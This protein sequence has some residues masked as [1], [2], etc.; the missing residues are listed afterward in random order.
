[1]PIV[2]LIA[3]LLLAAIF[4][5][6]I[7]VRHQLK[8]HAK[9][10]LDFPGTGGELALH[11]IER[12]G[13]HGVGVEPAKE[14]TDHYDPET[15]T[16]RLSRS[17]YRGKSISAIAVAAHEVG[18]AIQHARNE[19][20]FNLRISLVKAFIP[21][22]KI[23]GMLMIVGP[24]LSL[25]IRMPGL[26]IV[27]FALAIFVLVFQF[28]VHLATLPVEFDASFGKALPILAGGGYLQDADLPAVRSV[29]RAAALTY[30]S[31]ALAGVFNILR[32][33]RVL[34]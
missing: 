34:R 14:G 15:R 4:L 17:F 23:A 26:S 10:R 19:R 13:L 29:L 9:P 1:M 33:L 24:F 2:L 18:H 28:I 5:P 27:F 11:L 32:L 30:V 12:A 16:V 6:S 20:L 22:N 3:L 21:I 25:M 31:S 7:W 8:R